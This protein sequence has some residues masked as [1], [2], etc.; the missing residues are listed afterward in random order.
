MSTSNLPETA[1]TLR[2]HDGRALGYVEVGKRDGFPIFYFHGHHSSRL[3]LLL[4]TE[5][6][7]ALGVRMIALDRP[8]IGRSD[9]KA[10]YQLLDWPDD[11][12]EVANQL[13]IERFAIAAVSGGGAYGLA[14]AYKIPHRLTACGLICSIAPGQL[15]TK[16]APPRIR[17]MWWMGEHLPWLYRPSIRLLFATLGSDAASIDKR[18]NRSSRFVG[19]PDREV[20]QNAQTRRLLAQILAESTRQGAQGNLDEA[21]R[22]VR[23]WG[24]GVEEIACE[25]IFLWHGEQ[26]HFV[27]VSLAHAL[28]QA[29]PHCTATFYPD[30][31]H[32]STPGNHREDILK[33]LSS[34]R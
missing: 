30:E 2:L 6:A 34:Q 12:V 14:C 25:K 21:V 18:L 26:D 31:G 8:G 10:G 27:P 29:L 32:L 4:G 13:G 33:T 17:A 1:S 15:I 7:I 5:M 9:P 28:A 19:K 20:L 24:F 11:V 23:P 3:E 16:E 22:F